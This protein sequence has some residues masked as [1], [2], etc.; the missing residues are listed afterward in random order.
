MRLLREA[1]DFLSKVVLPG[2]SWDVGTSPLPSSHCMAGFRMFRPDRRQRKSGP[3]LGVR[4]IVR[5]ER[6]PE[7]VSRDVASS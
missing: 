4:W 5:V 3:R 1:L 6:G 2:G 7:R